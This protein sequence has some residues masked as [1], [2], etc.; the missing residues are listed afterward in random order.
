[1]K[2]K[3]RWYAALFLSIVIIVILHSTI[4][5]VTDYTTTSALGTPVAPV[6]TTSLKIFNYVWSLN[7]TSQGILGQNFMENNGW[8][9][10]YA[11][12][13]EGFNISYGKYPALATTEFYQD[14]QQSTK[15]GTAKL[16]TFFKAGG[17]VGVNW[18]FKNP[19]TGGGPWDT[20]QVDGKRL[21]PG[22]DLRTTWISALDE[23][24]AT[25][26]TLQKNEVTVLWRPLQEMNGDWFWWAKLSDADFQA[27]WHDMFLYF[28]DTK[29]LNNLLW[30]YCTVNGKHDYI[31]KYP[32]SNYV[33]FTGFNFY[34]DSY[35]WI[36]IPQYR[37]LVRLGKPIFVPE[38]G[39]DIKNTQPKDISN[40]INEL[41]RRCP[42]VHLISF[43]HSWKD[44]QGNWLKI[45]MVDN[46]GIDKILADSWTITRDKLPQF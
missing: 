3:S 34:S 13:I 37:K 21:L 23:I 33:D 1:M 43:W 12:V 42:E 8:L 7:G 19:F 5:K 6:N 24:A 44:D 40:H 36:D 15:V 25:L 17:L 27:I 31:S 26:T 11:T 45:S 28:K 14:D 10:N 9:Q 4:S 46:F 41:Q 30:V 38:A 35:R 18:M 20:N 32:G 22:G 39:P 2:L 16:I 29:K